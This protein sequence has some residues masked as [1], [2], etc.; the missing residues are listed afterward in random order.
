VG[1]T[2]SETSGKSDGSDNR[3]GDSKSPAAMVP[4][5][6]ASFPS[7]AMSEL[8]MERVLGGGAF[9]QVWQGSWC[10]TPVAVK[11]ISANIQTQAQGNDAQKLLNSFQDEVSLLATMRHPNICLLI[12]VCAEG[13]HMAIVT[14]LV[15][16]GSLWDVLHNNPNASNLGNGQ[17][18]LTSE[19]Q[20]RALSDTCRGLAYLHHRV[21]PVLHRDLKSANL[22]VDESFHIK[23]CDFGLARLR[24]LSNVAIMTTQVGTVQW[25][26]PEVL[27]GDNT[28]SESADIFSLGIVMWEVITGLCPYD[29][30]S[31]ME[32]VQRIGG[33]QKH[34]Q[35]LR[36]Q[37]P[38][39]CNHLLKQLMSD[40]WTEDP[41]ARPSATDV[42]L[43]LDRLYSTS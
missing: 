15:P 37:I 9:G 40:C 30:M 5:A 21:P 11:I 43:R 22:L 7:I 26:A 1:T 34:G 8:R 42:L 36:P 19:Q 27:R 16:R 23:I 2:I 17:S 31:V 25:M 39:H 13:T 20:Y 3:G 32:I 35:P 10:G 33:V 12:G 28:Y 18:P 6:A 38:L 4:A 29:G 24:D 14:E 41:R